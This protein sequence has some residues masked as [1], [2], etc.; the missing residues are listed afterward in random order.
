VKKIR[1]FITLNGYIGEEFGLG[2]IL[3]EKESSLRFINFNLSQT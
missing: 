3:G 1:V 2:S